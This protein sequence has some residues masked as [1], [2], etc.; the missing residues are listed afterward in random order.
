MNVIPPKFNAPIP[1]Y[2]ALDFLFYR[3]GYDQ[4]KFNGFG[5][6]L[7]DLEAHWRFG[8][9]DLFLISHPMFIG[10][11]TEGCTP[12]P[13]EEYCGDVKGYVENPV[14][15]D[16]LL[17]DSSS[18]DHSL[19]I[20]STSYKNEECDILKADINGVYFLDSRFKHSSEVFVNRDNVKA[21]EQRTGFFN[22]GFDKDKLTE[23]STSLSD[24][25]VKLRGDRN[26]LQVDESRQKDAVLE[27]IFNDICTKN[28][29]MGLTAL[30]ALLSEHV[31][32][33]TG[34]ACSSAY[35]R[36]WMKKNNLDVDL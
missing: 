35:V 15:V 16:S 13:C 10:H 19:V 1:E 12:V 27:R 24:R 22:H 29:R 6:F 11:R 30:S 5:Y 23:F 28:Q 26:P 17:I 33:E 9:I 20:M 7:N 8:E 18:D 21:F 4:I 31:A 34:I 25:Q 3:W 36:K 14:K 2:V 32:E